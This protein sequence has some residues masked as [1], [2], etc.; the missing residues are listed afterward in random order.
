[1]GVYI[2]KFE[3]KYGLYQIDQN[4]IHKY[5]GKGGTV[6]VYPIQE[7]DLVR[8]GEC[9]YWHE[10]ISYDTCDK[11]IGHGFPSNYFCADGERRE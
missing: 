4:K 11:H 3:P 7:I 9:K 6:R 1:M 10:G 5:K 8:C 2:D